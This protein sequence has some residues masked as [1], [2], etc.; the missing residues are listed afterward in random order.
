[1]AETTAVTSEAAWDIS[2][3]HLIGQQVLP[4]Y[5]FVRDLQVEILAATHGTPCSG[6]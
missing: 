3:G 6:F 5:S 4:L 1:M 2:I